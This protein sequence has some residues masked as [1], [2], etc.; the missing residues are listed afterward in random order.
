MDPASIII[1]MP[2]KKYNLKYRGF[3]FEK[4]PYVAG[5]WNRVVADYMTPFPYN[6]KDN[7][8]IY[9]WYRGNGAP[10]YIDD[11]KIDVYDPK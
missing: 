3:D 2:H 11:F 10:V 1:C 9:V 5:Q 6:E 7:F 4:Q 8:D